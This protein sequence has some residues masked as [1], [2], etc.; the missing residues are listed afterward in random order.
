MERVS[1]GA[2]HGRS[3]AEEKRNKVRNRAKQGWFQRVG[4]LDLPLLN[5]RTKNPRGGYRSFFR[6]VMVVADHPRDF[7]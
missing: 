2:T 4:S 7:P 5:Q 1:K 3:R 6:G